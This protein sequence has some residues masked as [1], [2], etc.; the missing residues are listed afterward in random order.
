MIADPLRAL[1]K[2]IDEIEGEAQFEDWT[3]GRIL[4]EV[5]KAI[6]NLSHPDGGEQRGHW[7]TGIGD[8]ALLRSLCEEVQ[9][10]HATVREQL[11]RVADRI[12]QGEL[13]GEIRCRRCGDRADVSMHSYAVSAS[14]PSAPI[15]PTEIDSKLIVP[16]G[17]VREL[18]D[19]SAYVSGKCTNSEAAT[20]CLGFIV[21]NADAM[22]AAAPAALGVEDEDDLL[23]QRDAL[24]SCVLDVYA[25][26]GGKQSPSQIANIR[27]EL[28]QLARQALA[29]APAV[30]V[31]EA[32]VQRADAYW[33]S[34]V[35]AGGFGPDSWQVTFRDDFEL[36]DLLVA[37]LEVVK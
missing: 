30:V 6:A 21:R 22:L 18:R 25:I 5:R 10:M 27:D 23:G 2:A 19:L 29:A 15:N 11:L 14:D 12:E 4:V 3:Q 16:D 26:V 1:K 37:A 7:V 20:K 33:Q 34:K 32:M 13:V 36:R 17:W 8:V 9:D 28:P 31:D 35:T 24:E